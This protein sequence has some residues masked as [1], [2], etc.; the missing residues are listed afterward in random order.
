MKKKKKWWK[1]KRFKRT[2]KYKKS[3][4]QFFV[5]FFRQD[6]NV[7]NKTK[8]KN[9]N[10]N[11]SNK[12]TASWSLCACV[13]SEQKEMSS[14]E[15]QDTRFY[16][17]R[18]CPYFCDMY[19]RCRVKQPRNTECFLCTRHVMNYRESLRVSSFTLSN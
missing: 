3:E 17:V 5:D 9:N 1:K 10:N 13:R 14:R 16:P 15:F 6:R 19:F 8:Q 11:N 12:G 2:K 18:R 4:K 7:L